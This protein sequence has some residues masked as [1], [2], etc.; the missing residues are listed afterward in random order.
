MGYR[1][2]QKA[3]WERTRWQTFWLMQ[4]GMADTSRVNFDDI[5]RLPWDRKDPS[6]EPSQEDIDRLRAELRAYNE[7]QAGH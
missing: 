2:R 7:K 5:L 3:E 6:S 4:V 1:D